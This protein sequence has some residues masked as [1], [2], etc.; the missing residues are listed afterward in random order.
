MYPEVSVIIPT[1][2]SEKYIAQALESVF[3][4]TYQNLEVILIDDG[5]KDTTVSIAR[6]FKDPRLKIIE[7]SCNRG[8]SY[9]R[10]RGIKKA[11]G[12]WIALLDSDD[13]YGHQRLAELLSIAK[14]HS[15]DLIADDLFLIRDDR[16][17]HWS[18]LLKENQQ[19]SLSPGQLIDAVKFVTSDRPS[20]VNAKRTWSL[21]YTKPLIRKEFLTRNKIEYQENIHVGEDFTF[22]LECLW[23]HAHF[24]LINRPYYYYRTREFS[25]S[26]RK[27]IEYL[28]Q[29]YEI[30]QRFVE[31]EIRSEEDLPLFKALQQNLVVFQKKLAYH[32]LLECLR[33]KKF[34]RAIA[35]ILTTPSV[36]LEVLLKLVN[37]SIDKLLIFTRFKTQVSTDIFASKNKRY[38]ETKKDFSSTSIYNHSSQADKI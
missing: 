29:S 33:Q 36:L 19:L 17:R 30:T 26:T 16:R 4:Q 28:S 6:S 32:H 14:Q 34:H 11:R 9:S 24:Y 13:W 15:A 21:G 1:Y 23:H 10:N 38:I 7:N 22:Y 27:P 5:S 37:T 3:R 35:L 12:E 25:L 20:A 8:V 31:R 18:T 2:N